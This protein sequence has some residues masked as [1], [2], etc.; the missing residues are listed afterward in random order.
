MVV[1]TA[2][3]LRVAVQTVAV[4]TVAVQTV[5]VLLED[6]IAVESVLQVVQLQS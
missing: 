4:Q 3:V 2:A 5:A 6:A 1:L